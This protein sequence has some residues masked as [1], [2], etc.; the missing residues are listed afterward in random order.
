MVSG[1]APECGMHMCVDGDM[2]V[3]Q[4]GLSQRCVQ[5]KS[6]ETLWED[7]EQQVR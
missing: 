1:F 7:C 2:F 5:G 4:A 3:S 6:S